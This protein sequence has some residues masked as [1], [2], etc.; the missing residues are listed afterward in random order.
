MTKVN[1]SELLLTLLQKSVE[2]C[3]MNDLPLIERSMEQSCVARIFYYMQKTLEEDKHF[4]SLSSCN[5]D[6]EYNKNYAQ[7]KKTLRRPKGTRPDIVLHKRC[8][9]DSNMLVVEFKSRRGRNKIDPF[10]GQNIDFIK[11]EDFTDPGIYHYFLGVHV[12]LQK[13]GARYTYFQNG[14]ETP[15]EKLRE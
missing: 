1:K 13:Q 8:A 10:T 5:L 12:K 3:Y 7:I 2:K 11:L 9:N 15:R 6:S 4:V 14:E